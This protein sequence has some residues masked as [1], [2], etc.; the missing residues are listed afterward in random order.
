MD[1]IRWSPGI[2]DPT[3]M[4]WL[5]VVAYLAAAWLCLRAF[6]VEKA[7]PP[8]PYR[9][10]IKALLRVIRKR[11]P[12]PPGPARRAGMWLGLAITMLCL[13]INKQLD[14][15]T[16]LTELARVAAM[17]EG[18]YDNR[19]AVQLGFIGAFSITA[20]AAAVGLWWVMRGHLA[21]FR[22]ALV[23]MVLLIVF[24]IVRATS[25]HHVDVFLG[26]VDDDF[27]MNWVLELGGISIVAVAAARR[28]RK[29][30]APLWR[31]WPPPPEPEPPGP[32]GKPSAGHVTQLG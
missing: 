2:G 13:G 7:G 29:A 18:W 12:D 24:V 19:R 32:E 22:L 8:R 5:T 27:R 23:G 4:G 1:E 9:Q 28:L 16:L 17:S 10:A 3:V 30:G 6:M 31:G 20:L 26:A 11:W 14:L 15:Q 21:D 25:F